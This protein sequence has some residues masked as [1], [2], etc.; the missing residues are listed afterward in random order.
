AGRL[1]G[2]AR[3]RA[4]GGNGAGCA[5]L[6]AHR[7]A[8]WRPRL[9]GRRG[10]RH[11]CLGTGGHVR[12]SAVPAVRAR[13]DLRGHGPRPALPP[14]R[15]ARP[16]PHRPMSRSTLV[17]AAIVL[18]AWI[19]LVTFPQWSGFWESSRFVAGII[20]QVL[21]FAIFASSPNP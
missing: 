21:I 15:T 3:L 7:R 8:R 14:R 12:E 13:T 16:R 9:P 6:L 18:L 2:G 4:P 10:G 19:V 1:G 11:Q 17:R 20:R 5:D